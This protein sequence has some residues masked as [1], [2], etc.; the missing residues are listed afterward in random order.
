MESGL[1]KKTTLD[2]RWHLV[3]DNLWWR[4]TSDGIRPSM[5][6]SLQWKWPLIEDI[7]QWKT[8]I[9]REAMFCHH[10]IRKKISQNPYSTQWKYGSKV[11]WVQKSF[12]PKK[13]FG[14][15]KSWIWNHFGLEKLWVLKIFWYQKFIA[16]LACQRWEG[17]RSTDKCNTISG[18]TIVA[19]N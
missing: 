1:Q 3:D 9:L 11:F 4:T 12:G 10:K 8:T 13:R 14:S 6:D 2:G 16:K 5:E 17:S 7:L 18:N 19:H 15:E